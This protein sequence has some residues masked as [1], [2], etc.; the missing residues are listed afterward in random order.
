MYRT[1]I[2][3]LTSTIE[4][5][6]EDLNIIHQKTE[7]YTP[8]RVLKKWKS[9]CDHFY[10]IFVFQ[11]LMLGKIE[12]ET[13]ENVESVVVK[14]YTHMES[15]G[16]GGSNSLNYYITGSTHF[17]GITSVQEHV[18]LLYN[19]S[20]PE[21]PPLVLK[22]SESIPGYGTDCFFK[23]D[24]IAYCCGYNRSEGDNRGYIY[25]YTFNLEF[26]SYI[27]E[28]VVI[29]DGVQFVGCTLT[30]EGLLIVA[31]YFQ[32]KCLIYDQD[33]GY[34][35]KLEL[36]HEDAGSIVRQ[37]VEVYPKIILVVK[38]RAFHLYDISNIMGN[39]PDIFHNFGYDYHT[40]SA[41]NPPHNYQYKGGMMT[42]F[43]I[44]GR[45]LHEKGGL[46]QIFKLN[47]SDLSVELYKE[48]LNIG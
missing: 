48:K 30:Q 18:G 14:N 34:L 10:D 12:W 28:D 15:H 31:L 9:Y 20:S 6:E 44:A 4:N 35:N 11:E 42:Y 8:I 24:R 17:W 41:L 25:K 21:Q 3:S 27:R 1:D 47:T 29:K 26:A 16:K 36:V 22:G 39:I 32:N 46:I 33:G 19:L 23:G 37:I 43:A 45:M 13:K 2:N 5:I 7:E 38:I 40:A